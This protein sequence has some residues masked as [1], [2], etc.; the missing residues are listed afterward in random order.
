MRSRWTTGVTLVFAGLILAAPVHAAEIKVLSSTALKGVFSDLGPQFEKA[1]QNKLSLTFGP[2]AVVKAQI[3]QGTAFD[4]AIL[5]VPLTDALVASGKVDS[6]TRMIVARGGL[7]VAIPAGAPKPDIS[8]PEAFK[9][10]LLSASSIGYNGQGASRAATDAIFVKLGI[11]DDL[12]PKIKL[13]HTTASESVIHGD[14]AVGLGPMS[15]MLNS[16]GV[17]FVGPFPAELQ[18]YLILPASVATA[19]ANRDAAVGLIK[20]LTS[21]AAGSV[22]KAKGMEPG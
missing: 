8:T 2:A 19:S 20:F 17:E 5:T 1:T 9:R 4:V 7:G 21:P 15:E 22:L 12:K 14:V 3:D 6:S 16:S 11:A 13:V 18:W 10:M